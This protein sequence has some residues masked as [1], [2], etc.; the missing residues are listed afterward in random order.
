MNATRP[1]ARRSAPRLGGRR[2]A[3]AGALVALGAVVASTG[4]GATGGVGS[5]NGAGDPAPAPDGSGGVRAAS[6]HADRFHV[7][8][9]GDDADVV[10]VLDRLG[11]AEPSG[12]RVAVIGTGIDTSHPAFA[13][14][15]GPGGDLVDDDADPSEEPGSAFGH[16]AHVAGIVAQM[17]PEA[18]IL[19]IRALGPDGR[20]ELGDVVAA[21]DWARDHGA[22][23]VNMSFSTDSLLEAQTIFADA[24]MAYAMVAAA[25]DGSFWSWLRGRE[26]LSV[27]AIDADGGRATFSAR[28]TSFGAPG[29]GVLSAFPGGRWARWSGTSMAAPVVTGRLS[30]TYSAAGETRRGPLVAS[31]MFDRTLREL[32]LSQPLLALLTLDGYTYGVLPEDPALSWAGSPDDG[33]AP[34]TTVPATT[35]TTTVPP[36]TTTTTTTTTTVASSSST[37]SW[38]LLGWFRRLLGG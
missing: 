30:R 23:L 34:T 16:G 38:S 9:G 8:A 3:L 2:R 7:W 37:S 26:D 19:P 5:A 33:P 24:D 1:P 4:D 6:V 13:G 21:I 36:T 32:R 14:R 10:E 20:G 12:V 27:G 28:D 22:Q 31:E 25:G 18:T 17:D 29:V 11:R 35:T 15:L